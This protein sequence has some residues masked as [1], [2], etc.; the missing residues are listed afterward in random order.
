MDANKDAKCYYTVDEFGIAEMVINNP[1]MN[2]L[3]SSIL[4]EIEE[5]VSKIKADDAV[6]VVV[7][8]GAGK[9]FVAGA[10]I[11]EINDINSS[12]HGNSMVENGQRIFNSIE[13]SDKPFIAAINGFCLGGG[14]ELALACHIRIADEKAK[15]G[16]PEI[17][18]GIIPGY[19][20]TQR[21]PR[22]IGKGRAFELILSGDF[23]S[24]KD[25]EL[26]GLVNRVS[27][28]GKSVDE[29]KKLAKVIAARGRL[30]VKS[31]MRAIADGINVPFEEGLAIERE[32]FSKIIV[33]EDKKEGI[34]A[35][36]EKRKPKFQ[37]K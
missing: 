10:D 23:I 11:K 1:P 2:A 19:G 3:S 21:T 22:L 24:G 35:F 32:Q 16:L 6:R 25:A 15:M 37:D 7:L 8:T 14:M 18:L 9:A 34:S 28:E 33:S 13:N 4:T 5:T 17:T 27:P 31:I 30:A 12:H 26:Y 36:I 20:G 29:A